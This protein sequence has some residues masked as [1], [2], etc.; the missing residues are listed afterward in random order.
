MSGS[1]STDVTED[2]NPQ[3]PH[4]FDMKPLFRQVS[5]LRVPHGA[6]FPQAC[7]FSVLP[8]S[9]PVL[10]FPLGLSLGAILGSC[11][12]ASRRTHCDLIV[13][14]SPPWLRALILSSAG[15]GASWPLPLLHPLHVPR[16][17]F[18]KLRPDDPIRLCRI[19]QASPK[20][21]LNSGP[22]VQISGRAFLSEF[23]REPL[24]PA[25]SE[26]CLSMSGRA[27]L[28][29]PTPARA[30]PRPA[31]ATPEATPEACAAPPCSRP[32]A[33]LSSCSGPIW[34]H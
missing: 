5:Q 19:F 18:Q 1:P 17:T 22:Q 7:P 13:R 25:K 28:P 2:P 34:N 6:C 14:G 11:L 8:V 32:V 31:S 23:P 27:L 3:R 29:S 10:S 30:P 12:W 21:N 26:R 33:F 15:P 20:K 24:P 16:L 9:A 4:G